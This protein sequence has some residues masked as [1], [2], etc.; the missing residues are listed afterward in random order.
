MRAMIAKRM[1]EET[2]YCTN[3]DFIEHYLP[4]IPDTVK[5][6]KI[7]ED[8]EN[9]KYL[10]KSQPHAQSLLGDFSVKP[11]EEKKK[12]GSTVNED[13]IFAPLAS[14]ATAI[15]SSAGASKNAFQMRMVPTETL[16]SDVLGCNFR[17]DACSTASKKATGALHITDI[18]VPF[19]FKIHNTHKRVQEAS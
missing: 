18:V 5:L 2:V 1:K 4:P 13:I 10:V 7:V 8:L 3:D 16:N 11:S 19:E 17:I 6:E 14:V 15:R 9:S 12:K